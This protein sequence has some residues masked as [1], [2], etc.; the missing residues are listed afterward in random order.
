[1]FEGS[2]VIP[3]A[4]YLYEYKTQ[5][6]HEVFFN[7]IALIMP[8]I[9]Q[10]TLWVTDKEQ[11]IRNAITKETKPKY[12]LRYWNYLASNIKD[13]VKN[14]KG[15]ILDQQFYYRQVTKIL[16]CNTRNEADAKAVECICVWDSVFT[17]YYNQHILPDLDKLG[18]WTLS[19][20]NCY[21]PLS[22]ITT[23]AAEGK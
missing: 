15:K 22:G 19:E 20:L 13:F 8:K 9:P 23:N 2:P 17:D 16:H 14:H 7:H 3:I 10:K 12:L 5:D 11:A 21:N 18:K 4:F 6:T 1:M